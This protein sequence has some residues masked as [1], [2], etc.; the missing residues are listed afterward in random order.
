[1]VRAL[2]LLLLAAAASAQ[3]AELH[4]LVAKPDAAGRRKAARA[5]AAREDVDL[6][7]WLAHMRAFRPRGEGRT[8]TFL[9]R[10]GTTAIA[11]YVP[12][13]YDPSRPAPLILAL[14]GAG[15]EGPQEVR[16][17]RPV[18]EDLG[19]ILAAP[20]ATGENAGYR[21]TGNERARTLEALRFVRR[22]FNVDENRIHLAGVSRGGHMTWDLG[23]RHPDAWAS[24]TPMIG[25]PRLDVSRGQNNLRYLE[26]V[27]H[28]PIRDLQGEGDDPRLLFNLRL[29]FQK[30]KEYGARDVALETFPEYGHG[31]RF[32]AVDWRTFFARAR[33]DPMP[34]RVVRRTARRGEG[35]AYWVEI[36]KTKRPTRETFRL[37]VEA[38]KW[39]AMD[40]AARRRFLA[41]EAEKRTARL[42]VEMRTPGVFVARSTG[43]SRFR[44]LLAEGM[45]DPRSPVR[46]T[47]N[48]RARSRKVAPERSVLLEEFAE[49]FDRTFLPIAEIRIP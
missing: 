42:E 28:V 16:R 45:F 41:D 21:F 47:W 8:G 4:V 10:A 11:L 27:A 34:A 13:R 37:Q 46:V 17:W 48:G 15:G 24:L 35:R 38:S 23:T 22:R 7:T 18:A 25:G 43:V 36:L 1:M 49:R 12:D 31:F 29:A 32:D 14:H 5:L 33:R 26:N 44:L 40:D 6:E 19:A 9:E 30:L 39:A 3:E 2:G 20:T